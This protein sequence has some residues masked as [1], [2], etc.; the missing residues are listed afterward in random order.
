MANEPYI[1]R[2]ISLAGW[3]RKEIDIAEGE[4]PG[5]MALREEY[6]AKKPLK[7]A[8]ITGSLHMTI[9]TAVLIETLVDLGAEVRWASCN[10]FSTQDHAAA[11]IAEQNIPV[12]AVKGESLE[13]YWDYVDRIFDWG[14]GET[15]NM[16][17]DDGGD[18]T[19][20]VLWGA[21]LEAGVEFPAP[22]NEEEEIFQKTVR[23]RVAA[24]P[25]FLTKTAKAIKGVSEETTTGVHRLYEI[26]KKG[27]LLFPAINVNDSVT[28]SKFDNLYGCKESLVDAIRRATDVMLAGKVACV[29][30]FG[31]VGKGSA[32]SLR[33]GG[34]RVLVTEVDPICA[35]QAAMEGY[36]VVTLEEAAP[37]ADIFVT[38]TGNAD[39]ITLDHMR[40]MKQHAIVCNIGHFDSEIQINSLANMKWTEI[41]PQVDLVKFPDGKEIIVLAK[42]RLVNLGCATGHPSF[43]MSASFT[44]QVLAQIELFCNT[45]KYQKDVYM[46]PKHLDEKV[47]A[48]HLP[49]LGVHLSKLTQKQA[50]YIGVPVNGPFK[51]DHYR[52]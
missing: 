42:G 10:I 31:D 34:A 45:D 5:L 20:F 40:A 14:K 1:V 39:I 37:R 48:L 9:Q 52:Y 28:K 7:G 49:K 3:G 4:M 51:P 17:L 24:T 35:L 2:D 30:G 23:R 21:K 27:E 32:A 41:K 43:V 50:D 44:N 19:M 13:E 26:A 36:E 22:Q 29:A 46:L 11:A 8:R 18:A 38:C 15:A 33:N 12:F 47:A 25:G 16:I 6:A